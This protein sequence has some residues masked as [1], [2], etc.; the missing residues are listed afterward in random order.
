MISIFIPFLILGGIGIL[1][2]L[3]LGFAS[4]NFAVTEDPRQ[5]LLRKCL[6]GANCGGCGF[7]GCDDYARAVAKGEALVGRCGVGG[8]AVT[9]KM[10][11]IMGVSSADNVPEV[12]FAACCGTK[13]KA[14]RRFRYYGT[15]SCLEAAMIP[16]GSIKTCRWGCLGFGECVKVCRFDAIHMVNGVALVDAERCRAC[17]ACVNACPKHLI[18]MIP[19]G[20]LVE[21]SCSSRER[22]PEVKDS[23]KAG[24]IGCGICARQ[25]PQKAITM[26]NNLP[27]IDHTI[28]DGCGL[29]TEKCPTHAL[30]LLKEKVLSPEDERIQITA[31]VV[32]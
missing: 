25:C 9:E 16:G 21:V 11:E 6:P 10:A 26:Q 8:P 22:G 32:K 24:C 5:Q 17:G 2:G 15:N 19:K 14:E 13:D 20:A 18:R 3:L 27:V 1:A 12:A 28:C 30:G 7:A 4:K 29:C 31:G 23:C